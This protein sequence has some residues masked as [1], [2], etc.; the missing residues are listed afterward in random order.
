[1]KKIIIV[2]LLWSLFISV[3]FSQNNENT[4]G[5]NF[6][7]RI[8]YNY[9]QSLNN[10]QGV[11]KLFLGKFNA[12]VE[13]FFDPSTEAAFES[14]PS[15][16]RIMKDSLGMSYILEIKYISNYKEASK[17]ASTKYPPIGVSSFQIDEECLKQ[18]TEH[19]REAFA[20]QKEEKLKLFKIENLFFPVSDQFAEKLYE[21]TVS[22]IHDFN[23]K[24]NPELIVN[25]NNSMQTIGISVDG[26]SV[27]F[28]TIVEGKMWTLRIHMPRGNALKMT[29]FCRRIIE[30][31]IAGKFSE[32]MYLQILEGRPDESTYL[33]LLD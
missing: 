14:P 30:D 13:F 2:G 32:L 28:R 24:A 31:A 21:K 25:V 8:E 23:P 29:D 16:F 12:P 5:E 10:K 11:E 17:E 15:C 33:Q 20:K 1:M 22:F 9:V 19:N 4:T 7:K 18:I 27:S 26:Y 3:V 6:V